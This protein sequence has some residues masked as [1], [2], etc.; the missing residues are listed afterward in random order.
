M[1]SVYQSEMC[2]NKISAQMMNDRNGNENQ[3]P[4]WVSRGEYVTIYS[5]SQDS[6][7][8]LNALQ[9]KSKLVSDTI[10]AL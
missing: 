1:N 4:D 3:N 8:A 2:G 6:L 9:I 7:K 5:D 10:Y